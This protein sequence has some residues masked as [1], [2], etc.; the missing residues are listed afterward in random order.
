MMTKRVFASGIVPSL[1]AW[2]C[3]NDPPQVQVAP[4]PAGSAQGGNSSGDIF[5]VDED[6]PARGGAG[7]AL[8]LGP[9]GTCA[10][11]QQDSSCGAESFEGKSVPVDIYIVFDQSGSM[12]A[13]LDPG[14]GQLC[15]ESGCETTR[16][17]A[18]RQAIETFTLDPDSAGIGVEALDRVVT[19][20]R[21]PDRAVHRKIVG[22]HGE[23]SNRQD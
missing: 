9:D 18:V 19:A 11:P 20:I 17:D 23:R 6:E 21:H 4:T 1:L 7:G 15:V 22:R 10:A 14:A 2:A 3:A 16:L 13:C 8:A 12:C 5:L